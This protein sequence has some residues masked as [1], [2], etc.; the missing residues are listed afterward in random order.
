MISKELEFGSDVE[1]YVSSEEG[2]EIESQLKFGY[3]N[4]LQ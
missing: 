2:V 4:F 1:I 3:W